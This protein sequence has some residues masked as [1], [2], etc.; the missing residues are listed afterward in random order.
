V[1][2]LQKKIKLLHR[3]PHKKCVAD[4][5]GKKEVKANVCHAKTKI[6]KHRKM[7]SR[8]EVTPELQQ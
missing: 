5:E 1:S 7:I 6:V 2:I 3:A 8:P 4:R